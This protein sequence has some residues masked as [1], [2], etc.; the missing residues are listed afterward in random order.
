MMA[1]IGQFEALR[2]VLRAWNSKNGVHFIFTCGRA[3]DERLT[4]GRLN[5]GWGECVIFDYDSRL[6]YLIAR[7]CVDVAFSL[8][9]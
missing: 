6:V 7:P 1:Q 4:R 8:I 5:D 2:R 3:N 9:H